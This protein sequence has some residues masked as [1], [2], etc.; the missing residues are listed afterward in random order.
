ME[1][2]FLGH[3]I[4]V[5][6]IEASMAKVEKILQWPLPRS[7]TDIRAFLGLVRYVAMFLPKLTKHT[8]VL[9]PLTMKEANKKFPEWMA[10]HER[11]FKAIKALVM[12]RECLTT[13]D[14]E[15]PGENKIFI[16]CDASDWQTGMMLS[17][18][19]TWESA[20]LVAFNSTQLNKAEKN[21]PI[22]KKE[23]LV[24]VHAL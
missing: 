6:G 21:Y 4:S 1:V 11:A 9:M 7:S 19:P 17:Y 24:I 13:I 14:H 20:R 2:D 15:N 23:L 16:T 22:H 12:S 8:H 3:H 18:G 10:E 5:K